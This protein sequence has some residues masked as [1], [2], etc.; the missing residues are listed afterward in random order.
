V[1]Y[2]GIGLVVSILT[3]AGTVAYWGGRVKQQVA[4]HERRLWVIEH[5]GSPAVQKLTA[6]LDRECVSTEEI[7]RRVADI[8]AR[9]VRVETVLRI[10]PRLQTQPLDG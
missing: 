3:L 4:M 10:M 2:V 9:L 8:D 7:L 5:E 6:L 1:L